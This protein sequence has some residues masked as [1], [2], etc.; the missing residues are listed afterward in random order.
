VAELNKH[1]QEIVVEYNWLDDEIEHRI[2]DD[3]ERERMK[4]L[5]RE[6]EQIWCLEEIKIRQRGRDRQIL[7]GDRNTAYF[8]AVANQRSRKK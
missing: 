4:S 2:L 5:A 3:R 7:K 1:K 6:L 8:H